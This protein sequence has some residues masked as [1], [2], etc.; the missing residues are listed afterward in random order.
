MVFETKLEESHI[1]ASENA[2]AIEWEWILAYCI[3]SAGQACQGGKGQEENEKQLQKDDEGLQSVLAFAV[4]RCHL[5]PSF[6]ELEMA[7]HHVC[8]RRQRTRKYC[9]LLA[10]KSCSDWAGKLPQALHNIVQI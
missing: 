3:T 6:Q 8:H 2:R 4:V 10:D 7:Q 1:E 5:E 9:E